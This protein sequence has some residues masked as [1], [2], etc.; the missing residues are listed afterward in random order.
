[1]P[2]RP[3]ELVDLRLDLD[4]GQL[5]V[6]VERADLHFGIEVADVTHDRLVLHLVHVRAGDDVD[7]AGG[8]DED[9]AVRGGVIH[10]SRP[11]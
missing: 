6:V 2:L 3:G 5:L 9:V 10:Q 7:V 1:L 4:L 8:G 11:R